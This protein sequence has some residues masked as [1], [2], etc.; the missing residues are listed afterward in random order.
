[1]NII[2]G[3][4]PLLMP[5]TGIGH[6]TQNLGAYL[7]E[8]E[9]VNLELFAHA[10]FFPNDLLIQ[11]S[12]EAAQGEAPRQL[13]LQ[14]L[15]QLLSRSQLVVGA[16][17]Q[18]MPTLN[19]WVLRNHKDALFHSPNFIMPDFAGKTVVTVHD[20]S[21]I[22]FPEF[23]PKARVSL[24]NRTITQACENADLL[25]TDSEY[26]KQELI[27]EFNISDE[28]VCAVPL[29]AAEHFK[30][31][32]AVE[33]GDVL[34]CY[35]LGYE[36]FFL[37]VS[38]LEPRKNLHRLLEA[39]KQYRLDFPDG[40][41]LVLVGSSGWQQSS[42]KNLLDEMIASGWVKYLG[43]VN[44]SSLSIL[45]SAAKALLFPSLYE[46]FG[47]PVLEAMQSGTNVLTS[48][49]SSMSEII[50]EEG[51]LIDPLSL[52]SIVEGIV[53]IHKGG[54]DLTEKREKAIIKAKQFGWDKCGLAMLSHYERV[55]A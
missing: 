23:H 49:D 32:E 37:F 14:R 26:V 48:Q 22:R 35:D 31:R 13:P 5:L 36:E 40:L 3:C 19:K 39:F 16:Y 6:Y 2:L 18:I 17:E 12:E 55:L 29:G 44:D 54:N 47:L 30:P 25:V 41:P 53:L 34:K 43:Y 1:M 20:L 28:R 33:C 51:V 50:D 24:V 4:D 8:A 10:K 27:H 52:Q 7:E 15:R 38:T 21:T 45:I 9:G 42:F 11:K 46:G